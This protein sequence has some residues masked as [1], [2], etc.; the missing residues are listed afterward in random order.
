MS[1]KT[2]IMIA[3]T[4]MIKVVN[5]HDHHS[6]ISSSADHDHQ[7]ANVN[8]ADTQTQKKVAVTDK[9]RWTEERITKSQHKPA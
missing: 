5:R 4:I 9:I 6:H 8:S 1:K 3:A 7:N 2:V